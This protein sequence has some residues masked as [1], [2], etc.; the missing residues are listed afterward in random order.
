MDANQQLFC[1]GMDI[2]DLG[3]NS[4][5]DIG[6]GE[7]S[8]CVLDRC[9]SGFCSGDLNQGSQHALF[10]VLDVGRTHVCGITTNQTTLCWGDN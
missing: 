10:T 1:W 4:Y 8:I 5:Y 6:V 7:A 9:G 2:E 3:S